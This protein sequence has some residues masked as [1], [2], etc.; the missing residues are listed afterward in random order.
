MPGLHGQGLKIAPSILLRLL[1]PIGGAALGSSAACPRDTDC[2][3]GYALLGYVGGM[4]VASAL[5]VAFLARE[6]DSAPSA[7]VVRIAP[8]VGLVRNGA[9]IGVAG[10]F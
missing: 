9:N 2:S 4:M 1:A 5:D 8:N 10:E 6:P 3:V 7:S